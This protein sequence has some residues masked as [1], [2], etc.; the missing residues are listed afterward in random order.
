[1]RR[2]SEQYGQTDH[3]TNGLHG[4]EIVPVKYGWLMR[5][6][7]GVVRSTLVKQYVLF[8]DL[9]I[10]LFYRLY[11]EK[12]RKR[13]LVIDRYFYDSLADVTD[14]RRWLYVRLFLLIAPTPDVPVFVDVNPNQAFARKGEYSVDYMERRRQIYQRIFSWVHRPIVLANEDLKAT[15]DTLKTVVAER[16]AKV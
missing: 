15:L 7:L 11:L 4:L 6:F 14:G 8:L 13:I 3:T 12:V 16:V 10:L 5:T 1:L 2:A 9:P